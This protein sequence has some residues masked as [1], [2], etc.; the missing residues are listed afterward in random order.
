MSTATGIIRT[1]MEQFALAVNFV[2]LLRMPEA[3]VF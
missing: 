3:Q 1:L 2:T